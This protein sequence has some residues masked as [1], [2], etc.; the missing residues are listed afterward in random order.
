MGDSP[1]SLLDKALDS[2]SDAASFLTFARLLAAD[3][4]DEVR[5]EAAH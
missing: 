3:R 5:K 1:R 4:V 2:I